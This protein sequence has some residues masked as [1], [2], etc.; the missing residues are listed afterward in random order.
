MI[1]CKQLFKA[2]DT[3]SSG[4]RNIDESLSVVTSTTWLRQFASLCGTVAVHSVVLVL[5]LGWFDSWEDYLC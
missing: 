3:D 2:S 1:R 5:F 4:R